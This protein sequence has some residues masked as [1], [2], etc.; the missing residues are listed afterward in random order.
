MMARASLCLAS[1]LALACA[2]GCGDD[3]GMIPD[4]EVPGDGSSF[5]PRLEIG[6]GDIGEFVPV[7]DGETVYLVRGPQGGQHVWVSLRAERLHTRPGLIRLVF[8]RERDMY[9]AS[10]PFE[11]RLSFVDEVPLGADYTQISG[12]QLIV[13]EPADVLGEDMIIRARVAEDMTG[14][15]MAES[16]V[17][18]RVEWDPD[19]PPGFDGSD[20]SV[21]AGADGGVVDAGATDASMGDDGGA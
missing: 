14:G 9:A 8:E 18:V 12:L 7:A 16:M 3:D 10:I 17:R 11:V 4:G 5:A 21:D 2:A 1:W 15:A 6:T 13:P 20:A 19:N